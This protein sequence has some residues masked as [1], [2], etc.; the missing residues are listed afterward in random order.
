MRRLLRNIRLSWT[1]T[2]SRS[3]CPSELEVLARATLGR[4]L[5]CARSSLPCNDV[6]EHPNLV[7][8]H[9]GPALAM[10]Q[11]HQI[12]FNKPAIVGAELEYIQEAVLSGQISGDG[13][14]AKRCSEWFAQ[15]LS[16]KNVL[17]TPSCTAALELAAILC[18][19]QPGDEVI[20]PSFTFVS[21]ANAVVRTGAR[22]VFVDIRADTLN[23]DE[24]QLKTAVS[25]RTKAVTVVHYG[26][27]ACEMEP[28]MATAREHNLLVVEDAAQSVNAFYREQPLGSIGQLGTFSFHETKN[29]ICGEGGALCVNDADL[30]ERALIIRDKGTNRQRF[31]RGEVDKYSWVD[32]GSSYV[33]GEILCAFLLAQLESLEKI[34]NR[35]RQLFDFYYEQL[36]PLEAQGI[37]RLPVVP[38]HCRHNYHTF[39]LLMNDRLSRDG[40]LAHLRSH[41]I[42]AVFHYVPLHSSPMGQKMGIARGDLPTTNQVSNRIVRLPMYYELD[43]DA[44]QTVVREVTSFCEH[45]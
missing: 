3:K 8:G 24:E 9:R 30:V 10:I 36:Q 6:L 1:T 29:Y 23:L 20:M 25:P 33:T 12:P 41:G 2:H 22:P 14:F 17:M 35:R 42:G 21:T 43:Q 19:L 40:L 28:I 45:L 4:D 11:Q 34:T 5:A 31:F 37:L 38:S 15:Q 39:Y 32:V 26:G 44:Q 7:G 27:V 18:D 16:I 13:T